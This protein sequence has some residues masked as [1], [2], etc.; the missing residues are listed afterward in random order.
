MSDS[1]LEI[2]DYIHQERANKL[3]GRL[4]KNLMSEQAKQDS[5]CPSTQQGHYWYVTPPLFNTIIAGIAMLLNLIAY[6]LV[7][8]SFG[9]SF[10]IPANLLH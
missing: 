3:S 2:M 5:V 9:R 1:V 8:S 4:N 10:V 6:I 7:K